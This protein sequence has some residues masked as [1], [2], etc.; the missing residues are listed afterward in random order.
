MPLPLFRLRRWLLGM[1]L[2]LGL[3]P[4][5]LAA[6]TCSQCGKEIKPGRRY[7]VQEGQAYCSRPC[8]DAVLPKCAACG[9]PCRGGFQKDGRSYCSKPCLET[10]FP[11]CSACGA[12]AHQGV[13]GTD[14]AGQERF[15]CQRCA[16]GSRCF[17]C[18]LPGAGQALADGRHQCA[19]CARSAVADLDAMRRVAEDV[20]RRMREEL[21]LGTDHVIRYE[22]VDEPTLLARSGNAHPGRELGLFRYE[23]TVEKRVTRTTRG[24]RVVREEGEEEV[25]GETRTIMVLSH[26]SLPKLREVLA[27]ELAHDWMQQRYPSI[28]DELIKEGWAEYVAAQVNVLYG[29]AAM[30]RRMEANPDPVYGDGYRWAVA[31]AAADGIDG[32]TR[33][34]AEAN[35][36]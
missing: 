11:Q 9:K 17:C 31:I 12:R 8:L 20:R 32:L 18:S 15:F 28:D 30:N 22:L 21:G 29:Q 5:L 3:C 1:V 19:Q 26:L 35:R 34:F 13:L 7:V 23:K 6:V 24:G 14:H 36:P 27:H 10:T 25:T 4:W 2:L 16:A 33:R